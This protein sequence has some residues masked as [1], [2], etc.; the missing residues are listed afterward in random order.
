MSKRDN[1]VKM[2]IDTVTGPKVVTMASR[3][4]HGQI[5]PFD[6]ARTLVVGGLCRLWAFAFEH[7]RDDN[8]L[9]C[10]PDDVNHI[11]GVDKFCDI[12]PPEWLQVIN[13]DRI[14]LPNFL[15]DNGLDP[16]LRAA[17]RERKAKSRL[18]HKQVTAGHNQVTARH[19]HVTPLRVQSSESRVQ[20]KTKNKDAPFDAASVVGLDCKAWSDWIAY[21]IAIHKPVR[22]ASQAIAAKRLA[23]MGPGQRDAVEYSIANGYQGLFAPQKTNGKAPPMKPDHSA[24]WAEAR[25]RAKAV[26]FRDPGAQES[27]GA[28]MTSIKLY[29]QRMPS[30]AAVLQHLHSART[31]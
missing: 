11:V 4:C 3:L 22:P 20:S 5:T 2:R 19:N 18:R 28:Y 14:H 13:P 10:T 16:K 15:E 29:E 30:A 23:N 17:A 21:R 26:G 31:T 7:V 8:T 6:T 25:A 24:E 27:V 9:A 1:F 12:V